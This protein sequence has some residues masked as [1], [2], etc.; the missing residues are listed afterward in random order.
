MFKNISI[1]HEPSEKRVALIAGGSSDEREISLQSAAGA[2][3][4]LEEAG[5]QVEQFDPSIKADI[6]SL[7]NGTFDVAFLTLHGRGGE[8]GSIQGFLETIGLPYTCSTIIGSA[9]AIDKAKA[10]IM[11]E[12][13][14]VPT[15]K[16]ITVNGTDVVDDDVLQE[17]AKKILA[18]LG[19]KVVVKAATEGSSIGVYIVE[20]EDALIEALRDA[21][22]L[23]EHVVVEEYVA[24]R[25]LTCAVIGPDDDMIAL[26]II[27]IIPKNDSYDF[28]SKYSTG[29]C[30]HICPA[31]I[32]PNIAEKIQQKAIDA[33]L[34]LG[35][36]DV[37]RTDFILQP[38]GSFTALETNTIPG[39]TGMSLL[40][41]A[42]KAAG[43]SFPDLCVALVQLAFDK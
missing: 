22:E 14:G 9:L 41:D 17:I 25:E 12:A 32:D 39:M 20:S 35:C 27:E 10:K 33:H 43:V 28:E 31:E 30:E 26:P 7:V 18:D 34:C 2:K 38:D 36:K 8:D 29:G 21:L 19:S 40:P 5:Y 13:A 16:S 24:G 11:Y 23:D 6:E 3:Q 4:A 37:S 1:A 15:P 42:A